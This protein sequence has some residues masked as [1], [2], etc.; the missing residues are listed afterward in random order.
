MVSRWYDVEF[1]WG[2]DIDVAAK[3][4]TGKVRRFEHLGEILGML[5][6]VTGVVFEQDGDRVLLRA[7]K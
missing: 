2:E 7:G 5:T 3:R 4:V 1:E 6:K